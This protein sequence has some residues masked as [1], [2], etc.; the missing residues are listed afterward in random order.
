MQ[1]ISLQDVLAT[2]QEKPEPFTV[3]FVTYDK[4]RPARSGLLRT[5]ERCTLASLASIGTLKVRLPGGQ[6]RP[7]HTRLITRF[8]SQKVIY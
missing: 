4:R 3:S 8:N 6:V 7:I 1:V 2:I 5:Y